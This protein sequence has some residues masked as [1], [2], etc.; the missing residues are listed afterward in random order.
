MKEKSVRR[1]NK[2]IPIYHEYM[3]MFWFIKNNGLYDK[4]LGFYK[5]FDLEKIDD[6]KQKERIKK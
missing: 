1:I 6:Y 3:G 5:D 4:F 2:F